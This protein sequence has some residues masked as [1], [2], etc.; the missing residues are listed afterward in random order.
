MVVAHK[1]ALWSVSMLVGRDEQTEYL[2][3]EFLG[4]LPSELWTAKVAIGGCL[5]VDR[6]LQ[7]QF[8]GRTQQK[9]IRGG[10]VRLLKSNTGGVLMVKVA[11]MFCIIIAFIIIMKNNVHTFKKNCLT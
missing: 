5:L 1:E 4:N 11:H 9:Q 7:L 6:P 2:E 10:K 3:L 8:P